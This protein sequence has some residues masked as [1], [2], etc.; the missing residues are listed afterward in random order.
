M[1]SYLPKKLLRLIS[2]IPCNAIYL[3][4]N[5]KKTLTK[6]AVLLFKHSFLF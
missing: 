6:R 4:N 1:L 5:T 2:T 3:V